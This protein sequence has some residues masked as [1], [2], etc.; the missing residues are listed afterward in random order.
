MNIQQELVQRF[1]QAVAKLGEHDAPI[2]LSRSTRP[3]F[4]E[5]QFNGAMA[6][7]KRLKQKP[8]DIADK[9]LE[10]VSQTTLLKIRKGV[11]VYQHSLKLN[12]YNSNDTAFSQS[13]N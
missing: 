10:A 2:P 3:E 4:G 6:L 8:R 11:Q 7:A 9:I 5:Y 12:F 13:R 1:T